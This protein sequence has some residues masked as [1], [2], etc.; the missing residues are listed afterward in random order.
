MASNSKDQ[1]VSASSAGIKDVHHH[2]LTKY[3]ILNDPNIY[4]HVC[5]DNDLHIKSYK[6]LLKTSK[7]YIINMTFR[8]Y[9]IYPFSYILKCSRELDMNSKV[10]NQG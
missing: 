3:E 2:C 1:P 5:I 9:V 6:I 4:V 10:N 7:R 8:F